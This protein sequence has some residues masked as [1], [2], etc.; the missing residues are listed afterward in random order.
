MHLNAATTPEDMDLP[1]FSLHSL[2]GNYAGLWAISVGRNWR[3]MFRFA[4]G[5]VTDVDYL[6]YH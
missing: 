1:G 6:D 4:K 5:G 2:K 3:I